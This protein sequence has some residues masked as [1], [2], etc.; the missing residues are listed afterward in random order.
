M[1]TVTQLGDDDKGEVKKP[2]L[3][4][5]YQARLMVLSYT[6]KVCM[7]YTLCRPWA[8]ETPS[9]FRYFSYI[10]FSQSSRLP[11]SLS[12]IL[13]LLP[14]DEKNPHGFPSDLASPQHCLTDHP[15]QVSITFLYCHHSYCLLGF[16]II[17][18]DFVRSTKCVLNRFYYY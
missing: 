14:Q 5:A 17:C 15:I 6:Q 2:N 4:R 10:R 13:K 16:I 9:S 12:E 11:P 1:A 8:K 18:K 7:G 3:L